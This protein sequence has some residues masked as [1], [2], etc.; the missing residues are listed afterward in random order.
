MDIL[1]STDVDNQLDPNRRNQTLY[2]GAG[3][4]SN[5]Q[6]KAYND[7]M[8]ALA[9]N[10][11]VDFANSFVPVENQ[12]GGEIHSDNATD[13]IEWAQGTYDDD[14][15]GVKISTVMFGVYLPSEEDVGLGMEL[16][17][18]R[19]LGKPIVLAMPDDEFGDA[20]NL[21]A[22]GVADDFIKMSELADYDFNQV[23]KRFY[24]GSVY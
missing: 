19:Q 4:F 16:G 23:R 6:I 21:M 14:L 9:A 24:R 1:H 3:W 22:W 10:T 7:A 15:L 5:K 11:T 17:Y 18:A 2:F 20:I 8:K 13:D 12:F